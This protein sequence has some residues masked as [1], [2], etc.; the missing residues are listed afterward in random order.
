MKTSQGVEFKAGRSYCP[1]IPEH[2][3]KNMDA[4]RPYF[5]T[6]P[7]EITVDL[8][9]HEFCPDVIQH[10]A[11]FPLFTS[12]TLDSKYAVSETT[13]A[14][15]GACLVHIANDIAAS[16]GAASYVYAGSHLGS[17]LHGGPIPWDDDTDMM[18]PAR[19]KNEFLERCRTLSFTIPIPVS[20][21]EHTNAIKM[22]ILHEPQRTNRDES[23]SWT[24]PYVDIYFYIIKDDEIFEV[25]PSGERFLNLT[26]PE[27][28]FPVSDFFPTRPFY[29]AGLYILGPD[30]KVAQG[31]YNLSSCVLPRHN[32]QLEVKV[33]GL[34]S[35]AL[36][37]CELKNHFPFSEHARLSNIW[38]TLD[39]TKFDDAVPKQVVP[40]RKRF[41]YHSS[42][43]VEGQNLTDLIPHLNVVEI[44]NTINVGGCDDVS[45]L[46]V[47]VFNMER[48]KRWLHAS[49][50]IELE[51]PDVIILNE[52]DI[53]M[54]R[55]DQQHTTRLLAQMLGMNYA[56]GL[57]FVELTRGTQIEQEQTE[58]FHDFYGLHGNAILSRC[59]FLD[60]KIFRDPIGEYFSTKKS[61]VNA[62]GFE[63]RLG[64]RMA[65][66]TQIRVGT[67]SVGVGSLHKV[68]SE[69][70][71]DML[72]RYSQALPGFR[73]VFGGD[74]DDTP[75]KRNNLTRHNYANSWKSS[76]SNLGNHRGDMLCSNLPLLGEVKTIKPCLKRSGSQIQVADH[77]FLVATFILE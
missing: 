48:G 23:I 36:D 46:R 56:W 19:I 22:H 29:F 60:A 40:L 16:L 68:A 5:P 75:C 2:A 38:N 51:R 4:L 39:I 57:E 67:A 15:K 77:A 10:F 31:R 20:C 37:C 6:K 32:H 35:T 69:R 63:K 41:E 9:I 76:C 17:Y 12:S 62:G 42:P 52:M 25:S 74:Q 70:A 44:I 1:G 71:L 45:R 49:K 72:H 11:N 30:I 8:W 47:V 14:V 59:K 21:H 65:L 13:Y 50:L 55:S 53:G 18:L 34:V 64:G 58:N 27:K 24:S 28:R 73:T 33:V 3:R 61:G 54:A 66:M 43:D 26:V 7:A